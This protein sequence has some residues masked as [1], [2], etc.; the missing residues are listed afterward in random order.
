MAQ[1]K[2]SVSGRGA[3]SAIAGLANLLPTSVTTR[4]ARDQA[5]KIDLA[6]SNLRGAP[7]TTYMAGAKVEALFPLG[8]V[9]GTAGNLTTISSDGW[10]H[11]GLILDPAAVTD[12]AGLRRNIEE[13][14]TA[15]LE[16]GGVV[17]D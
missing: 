6:T 9:A 1:R 11:M 15:L 4:V 14:Y 7:I 5:A 3:M 17:S 8:P 16:A 12:P 2:T 13:A 10:L